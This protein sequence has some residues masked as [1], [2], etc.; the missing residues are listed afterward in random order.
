MPRGYKVR[1]LHLPIFGK[2]D[3]VSGDWSREALDLCQEVG[4]K[5]LVG[6][7]FTV[8]GFR[9][10]ALDKHIQ[11]AVDWQVNHPVIR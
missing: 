1:K 3:R 10:H 6:T 7:E 2:S 11:S 4:M 8:V 5:A 9:H